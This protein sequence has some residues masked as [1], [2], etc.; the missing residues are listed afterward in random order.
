MG[1]QARCCHRG[2]AP[3]LGAGGQEGRCGGTSGQG[4]GSLRR[5]SRRLAV[6]PA[7]PPGRATGKAPAGQ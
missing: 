4:V 6:P 7:R 1:R 2:G 5:G 3:R